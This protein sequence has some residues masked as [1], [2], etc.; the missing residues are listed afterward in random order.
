VHFTRPK[1]TKLLVQVA[2]ASKVAV[3]MGYLPAKVFV[4]VFFLFCFKYKGI[5]F[6]K[7]LWECNGHFMSYVGHTCCLS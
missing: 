4:F 1:M 5:T 6:K 7:I 3:A 2:E